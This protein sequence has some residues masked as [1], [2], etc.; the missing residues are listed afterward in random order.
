MKIS[1]AAQSGGL[2]EMLPMRAS[3]RRRALSQRQQKNDKRQL[4]KLVADAQPVGRPDAA[5]G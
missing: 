2:P 5:E 1:P 4:L 3:R